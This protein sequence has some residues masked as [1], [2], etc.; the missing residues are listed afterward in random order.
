MSD[1]I[2]VYQDDDGK[3][4][5]REIDIDKAHCRLIGY[6]NQAASATAQNNTLA[7]RDRSY[8][9]G[10]QLTAE[11]IAAQNARGQASVVF[12]LIEQKINTL[13]G[14]ERQQRRDIVAKPRRKM[15]DAKADA[16]THSIKYTALDQNYDN[17]ASEVFEELVVEG[18]SVGVYFGVTEGGE[19]KNPQI[20]I[21]RLS[22]AETVTDPYCLYRDSTRGA[23]FI[24]RVKWLDFDYAKEC[25]PAYADAL[26]PLSA[27]T[28]S[29][30]T[31]RYDDKPVNVF[32]D[33]QRARIAI[34]E[35]WERYQGKIYQ[36]IF[37]QAV[38]LY[39]DESPYRDEDGNPI[40]PF[41]VNSAY[42]DKDGNKY[43]VVR[44]LVDAQDEINHRHSKAIH[45]MSC[46]QFML[47]RTGT[48]MEIEDVQD[49][50]AKPDG[51]LTV[52]RPDAITMLPTNDM[53]ASQVQMLQLAQE[54]ILNTGARAQLADSS[55]SQSGRAA[56][57][58]Q[59]A[60]MAELGTIFDIH[61]EWKNRCYRKI[62]NLQK[63][64]WTEPDW[65]TVLGSNKE[66]QYIGINEPITEGERFI[67][68]LK[69]KKIPITPDIQAQADSLTNIVGVRNR[70]P[71]LDVNFEL[72]QSIDAPALQIEQFQTLAQIIQ[73]QNIPPARL[74]LLIEASSLNNKRDL[75]DMIK[76][77]QEQAAQQQ[78]QLPPD[79]QQYI[80]Q[81]E[82]QVTE[83]AQNLKVEQLK[84]QTTLQ[85]ADMDNQAKKD[86]EEI[87]GL[88]NL[89]VQNQ[90]IEQQ[91][92]LQQYQQYTPP[93]NSGVNRGA[94]DPNGRIQGASK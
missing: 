89:L 2:D 61:N 52:N 48:D 88:I 3:F 53:L 67:E 13:C 18:G 47:D 69:A 66:V 15:Q 72:E 43:G 92:D 32:Y 21:E 7:L 12:N 38:M 57:V 90:G 42:I 91:R 93:V 77:E 73:T 30:F 9:D 5:K 45:L 11:I 70:L 68:Q 20:N 81:L 14:L 25:Y 83:N 19:G 54:Y 41:E 50:L 17:L 75:L 62:W 46:R 8:R 40:W 29:V 4:G 34:Y 27:G 79:V 71:D 31:E 22:W 65:L 63:Q 44:G 87:K 51:G 59:S 78:T 64:F 84:A 24:G 35:V 80:Q 85:K 10:N 49:E 82:Q 23:R 28:G 6:V 33:T 74:Q 16:A 26:M 60:G 94:V 56:L 76:Q 58:E 55:P 86:I 1:I 37:T 36:G 39:Y